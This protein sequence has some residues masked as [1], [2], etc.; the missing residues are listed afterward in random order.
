MPLV[1]KHRDGAAEDVEDDAALVDARALLGSRGPSLAGGLRRSGAG[2]AGDGRRWYHL[3]PGRAAR[4][5]LAEG[6]SRQGGVLLVDGF[7]ELVQ[8]PRFPVRAL[9][10]RDGRWRS[11]RGRLLREVAPDRGV[12]GGGPRRPPRPAR[13]PPARPD[14]A[15]TACIAAQAAAARPAAFPLWSAW[16]PAARSGSSGQPFWAAAAPLA[17][18]RRHRPRA[19]AST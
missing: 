6:L 9:D 14:A 12:L 2:L 5:G 11:R 7:H 17:A 8:F 1:E 3:P 16:L 4:H 13:P 19:R 18:W 15:R 10:R